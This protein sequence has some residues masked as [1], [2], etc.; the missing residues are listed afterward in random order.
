M[1]GVGGGL[2]VKTS[3][4]ATEAEK[5]KVNLCAVSPGLGGQREPFAAVP[6]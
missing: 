2:V 4:E 1:V 6:H 5:T 3:G